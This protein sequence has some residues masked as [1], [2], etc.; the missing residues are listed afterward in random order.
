L[1]KSVGKQFILHFW[2]INR[3]LSFSK[4][5]VPPGVTGFRS[6]THL[7][8]SALIRFLSRLSFFKNKFKIIGK[9]FKTDYDREKT[10]AFLIRKKRPKINN[11]FDHKLF[12]LF[13]T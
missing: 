11:Q 10:E 5:S 6:Y 9:S 13:G 3:G 8:C 4:S 7:T 2:I 12:Q 1:K